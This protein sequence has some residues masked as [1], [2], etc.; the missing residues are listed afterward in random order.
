V[1]GHG[2]GRLIER[3]DLPDQRLNL[4]R[5]VEEAELGVEMKVNE[6]GSHDRIL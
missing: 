1:V 6:L 2:D 5:A 3:C 4:I